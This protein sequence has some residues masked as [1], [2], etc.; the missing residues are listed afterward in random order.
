MKR[1]IFCTCCY[2]LH[3]FKYLVSWEGK[4]T[5][6]LFLNK[7][8]FDLQDT[9]ESLMLVMWHPMYFIDFNL[10]EVPAFDLE[11]VLDELLLGVEIVSI[12]VAS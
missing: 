4:Q 10:T 12:V 3:T 6:A 2:N 11:D 9:M 8:L 5:Q 1:L 7:F